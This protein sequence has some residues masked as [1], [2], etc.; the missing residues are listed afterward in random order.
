MRIVKILTFGIFAS[1]TTE[2]GHQDKQTNKPD[3]G[4]PRQTKESPNEPY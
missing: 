4:K 2:I 3:T 1:K